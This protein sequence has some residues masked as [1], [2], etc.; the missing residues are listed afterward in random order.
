MLDAAKNFLEF[1]RTAT[2]E[3]VNGGDVLA[4]DPVVAQRL[5]VCKGCDHLRDGRCQDV[6]KPTGIVKGCGCVVDVKVKFTASQCP[7]GYW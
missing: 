2:V 3:Y 6:V 1:V 4:P 5:G 7:N